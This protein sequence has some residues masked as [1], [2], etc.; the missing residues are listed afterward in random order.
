MTNNL[1]KTWAWVASFFVATSLVALLIGYNMLAERQAAMAENFTALAERVV[2]D[3]S[4]RL[5]TNENGLISARSAVVTIGQQH[6]TRQKFV[7]YSRSLN[8]ETYFPGSRGFGYI[9]RVPRSEEAAFLDRARRDGKPDFTI[10]QLTPHEGE[11]FVIQYIEPVSNNQAAVGLDVA[12]ETHRR[13]AALHSI[14]DNSPILTRPITLV[15]AADKSHYGLLFFLPVYEP[16]APLS[17]EPERMRA[18][19]GWVYS[20]L[21]I[22]EVLKD[23]DLNHGE[24]SLAIY[25]ADMGV[26]PKP[27][28]ASGPAD[29]PVI[30][31]LI[32]EIPV[33]L[34]GREWLLKI[35]ATPVF[36]NNLHLVDPRLV[37]FSLAL[38]SSLLTILFY[39]WLLN[40]QRHR[41]SHLDKA[42]L[43]A[44]VECASNAIVSQDLAGV[45]TSWNRSAERIFGFDASEALGKHLDDL[46]VP[47]E[48]KDATARRDEL[49]RQGDPDAN[50]YTSVRRRKDGGLIEVAVNASL[51]RAADGKLAGTAKTF[52]DVTEENRTAGRF[53]M[54]LDAAGIAIWVW[55]PQNNRLIWDDR[56]L[57]LYGAPRSLHETELYYDFWTSHV[58][59]EDLAMVEDK[60]RQLLAGTGDYDPTFR[61]I[62]D[63][64]ELRW[65]KASA[66]LESD[67]TGRPIQMVGTN[68]DITAEQEALSDAEQANQAKSA[69]LSNMSHEIRTPMN[70]VLGMA[71]M[72]VNEPLTTEQRD[73]V[74]SILSAG[75]SLLR[76]IN[77]IL[78]FSKLDAGQFHLAPHPF[79]LEPMLNNVMAIL[80]VTAKGKGIGLG[81][82]LPDQKL[83]TLLG[84]ELRLE[85]ILFNLLGNAV[86]FT[87]QGE[88]L[89]RVM[90]RDLTT[91][92]ARLRFDIQD[93][94]IGIQPQVLETLFQ[95]FSQADSSVS[96]RFGGTGLG[97]SISKRL[98]EMMGGQ[99][100]VESTVGVGSVF[101]F[102]L[103]FDRIRET[104]PPSQP[105]DALPA[106]TSTGQPE[107]Q[108]LAGLRV[109]LVDD[110][111]LNRKVAERALHL[112]GASVLQAADGQQALDSLR[113]NPRDVDLVLMDIQ[114]PVMDGLTATR[115]I[116]KDPALSPL[117]VIA[118]TAGVLPEERQA[119]LDA[120]VNDFLPKPLDLKQMREMLAKYRPAT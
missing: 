104:P 86:K 112:A 75:R 48:L 117:P 44:I 42:K 94:G 67:F 89:V 76:I 105:G 68:L 41:E 28:F 87:E 19:H 52:S 34:Y 74:N 108:P 100:G 62:R 24:L 27:F 20:P 46:I 113:S 79:E 72:L 45:V 115:E 50:R 25:N 88:V 73:M 93:T 5:Q 18:A 63:D 59:P 80:A 31:G 21:N 12:S 37:G 107:D 69:F 6:L 92:R 58:H 90:V 38:V 91:S 22:D 13:E 120:G 55:N 119:A 26:E 53:R 3:I 15:Q 109:L 51:I 39:F 82:E 32:R 102:E 56:M 40:A 111:A 114:M 47:D 8:Q 35:K 99:I 66:I 16:G 57:E 77:D 36:V 11:R 81:A 33:S 43:A 84:D 116:R 65:I 60:L 95:P 64:G 61:I 1:H 17:S 14:R 78:D 98:V 97:L 106:A 110:S 10:R 103:D 30:Q 49:I 29:A 118:L 23:L 54:A 9:R 71:Q 70:G 101:W 96:R 7:D 4:Q 83:G 2:R 85:Q